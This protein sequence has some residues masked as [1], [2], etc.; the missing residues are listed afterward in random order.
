MRLSDFLNLAD[1]PLDS[2]SKV[3]FYEMKNFKEDL[4]ADKFSNL[5]MIGEGV[6]DKIH[7]P[8]G[9]LVDGSSL[10]VFFE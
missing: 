7:A 6:E 4:L 2:E 10:V 5:Y 1:L 3:E 9:L 8:F